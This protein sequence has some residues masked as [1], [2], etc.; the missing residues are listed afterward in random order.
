M[1]RIAVVLG[2]GGTVGHAFHAGVLAALSS[3]LGWDARRADLLVGT[4]AGSIV[5]VPVLTFQP[6][7]ADLEVMGGDALDPAN[8]A[9]VATRSLETTARRL[10]TRDVRQRLAVLI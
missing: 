1:G 3:E 5:T 8:F 6:A 2:A 4:S 7:A 9:P 10:A